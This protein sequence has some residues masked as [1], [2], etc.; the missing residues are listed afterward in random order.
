MAALLLL[1]MVS[2]VAAGGLYDLPF[3]TVE[4]VNRC[5]LQNDTSINANAKGMPRTSRVIL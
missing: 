4:G 1:G 3:Y 2:V 5:E